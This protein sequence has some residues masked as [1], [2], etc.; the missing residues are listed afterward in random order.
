[1][2]TVNRNISP[3]EILS[4]LRGEVFSSR[5]GYPDVLHLRVRDR[6]GGEWWLSTFYA[7]FS[8]SDPELF[9]GKTITGLEV[10]SGADLR[11][12]FADGPQ[13][14]VHRYPP[15]PDDDESD[16]DLETWSLI[17][18]EEIVLQHGPGDRWV[19]G[20]ASDPV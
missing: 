3:V 4:R 11:V 12:D 7:D 10:G 5:P 8:P 19:L 1:M 15:E 13:L 16:D 20:R 6:E 2:A 17:T 9:L 14:E 18:P